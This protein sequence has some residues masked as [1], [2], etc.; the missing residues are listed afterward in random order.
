LR[1]TIRWKKPAGGP[2]FNKFGTDVLYEIKIDNVGDRIDHISYQFEFTDVIGKRKI[3]FL[4][5]TGDV[6]SL[7][8]PDL[9]VK[10]TYKVKRIVNGNTEWTSSALPVSSLFM[11][12]AIVISDPK[13]CWSFFYVKIMQL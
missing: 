9:N 11:L 10:Q 6:T 8:D 13:L 12:A 7:T 1:V 4:Y 3:H 5:N 2:N